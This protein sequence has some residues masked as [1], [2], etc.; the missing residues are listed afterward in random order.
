MRFFPIAGKLGASFCYPREAPLIQASYLQET[1]GVPLADLYMYD[2]ND[3]R[4]Y[5]ELLNKLPSRSLHVLHPFGSIQ[6]RIYV[7]DPHTLFHLNNKAYL[8]EL[9][10]HTPHRV[11][12]PVAQV[13]EI[14]HPIVL[15]KETGSSGDGVLI[16]D[17][18]P[19]DKL[20]QFLEGTEY[21]IAEQFIEVIQNWSVQY[22]IDGH[23]E[24]HFI[25][26]GIQ[27]TS[28]GGEF[29]GTCCFM[30]ESQPG[31][32]E[33]IAQQVCQKVSK[34]GYIGFVGLD[35]LEDVNGELYVIDPNIRLT[36]ASSPYLLRNELKKRGSFAYVF[37]SHAHIGSPKKLI[38]TLE[39][40]DIQL[41]S[42]SH[43]V[44]GKIKY[45]AISSHSNMNQAIE[46]AQEV[47]RK[48][49]H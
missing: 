49:E 25:G 29:L 24:S 21:V 27:T 19:N 8:H 17:G 7:N 12:L 32:L 28:S 10:P 2:N 30:D 23:G 13:L 44:Q 3:P 46:H 11:V 40:E 18:K 42:M 48:N 37:S 43:P 41:L 36:A 39:A 1:L 34:T 20:Q 9:T 15:K 14:D 47:K 4:S 33:F 5:N 45:F 38:T 35:I 6:P 31:K 16:L 26:K 22:Y